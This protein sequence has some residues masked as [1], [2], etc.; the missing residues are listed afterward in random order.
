MCFF[1]VVFECLKFFVF[2][3]CFLNVVMKFVV[4]KFMWNVLSYS[5][6]RLYVICYMF[7]GFN[8]RVLLF[9]SESFR[10]IE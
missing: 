1:Y 3:F 9:G 6:Y 5:E 4:Y 10:R 7:F 2:E 8:M